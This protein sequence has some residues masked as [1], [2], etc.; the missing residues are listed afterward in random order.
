MRPIIWPRIEV[1]KHSDAVKTTV[2]NQRKPSYQGLSRHHNVPSRPYFAQGEKDS[3]EHHEER[4]HVLDRLHGAA[5][6]ETQYCLQ[7]ETQGHRLTSTDLVGEITSDE[8]TR[9]VKAV[10]DHAPAERLHQTVASIGSGHDSRAEDAK[11]NADPVV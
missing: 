8:R 7:R 11:G 4:E 1:G 3:V 9:D 10:D 5:E 6:N 2:L